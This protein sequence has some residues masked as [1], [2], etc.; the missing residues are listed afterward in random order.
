MGAVAIWVQGIAHRKFFKFN[1]KPVGFS[2]FGRDGDNPVSCC[3]AVTG[4]GSV[5][6]CGRLS[7]FSW[8]WGAL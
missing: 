7:Q 4:G 6:E 1:L 3:L 5:G 2:K 8:L